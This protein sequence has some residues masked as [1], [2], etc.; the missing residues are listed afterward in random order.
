[1]C[2]NSIVAWF[3]RY[4]AFYVFTA[5]RADKHGNEPTNNKSKDCFDEHA[6]KCTGPVENDNEDD[7]GDDLEL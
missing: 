3:I 7:F 5:K 1:M 2:F 6:A 4:L